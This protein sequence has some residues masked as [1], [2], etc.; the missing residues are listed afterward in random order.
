MSNTLVEV[1]TCGKHR[2]CLLQLAIDYV[3]A[4]L[5]LEIIRK[6]EVDSEV[7]ACLLLNHLLKVIPR[8]VYLCL[9]TQ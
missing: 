9:H 3:V 4:N 1:A 7:F 6:V 5:A 2:V 8:S